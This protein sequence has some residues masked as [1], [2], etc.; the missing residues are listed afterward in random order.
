M[1]V[2]ETSIL[3][4]MVHDSSTTD[5]KIVHLSGEVVTFSDRDT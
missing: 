5:H 2:V 1:R 3:E 4:A